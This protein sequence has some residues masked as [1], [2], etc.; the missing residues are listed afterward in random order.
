MLCI[1]SSPSHVL[2]RTERGTGT[3]GVGG[4]VGLQLAVSIASAKDATALCSVLSQRTCSWDRVPPHLHKLTW[5]VPDSDSHSHGTIQPK[6]EARHK[7]NVRASQESH[8]SRPS[9]C[10]QGEGR[11]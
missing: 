10:H 5:C 1:C 4:D 2:Y 3:A 8:L 9:A 7:E 6:Q 11:C